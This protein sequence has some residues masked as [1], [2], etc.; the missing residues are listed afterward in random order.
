MIRP[1]AAA[2]VLHMAQYY[3]RMGMVAEA[4]ELADPL[5]ARAV[6]LQPDE[7]DELRKLM[8]QLRLEARAP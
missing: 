3:R 5:M 2:L 1:G 4:R 8:E 6:E 7:Y